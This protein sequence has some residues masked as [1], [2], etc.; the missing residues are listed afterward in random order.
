MSLFESL[1]SKVVLFLAIPV[2]FFGQRSG[3]DMA[4][5]F[6]QILLFF[7]LAYNTDCL[8]N[9]RCKTWAW[10]TILFPIIMVIG[11]LFFGNDL[12]IPPPVRIPIPSTTTTTTQDQQNA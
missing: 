7:A 8:V 2:V 9:G 1:Q 12:N 11:Y 6:S 5:L 3:F 10:L 4:K